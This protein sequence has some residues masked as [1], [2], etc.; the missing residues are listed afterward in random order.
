MPQMDEFPYSFPT[1]LPTI[2]TA[3]NKERSH[4]CML[5]IQSFS[6]QIWQLNLDW[7]Y[8]NFVMTN[9]PTISF[10]VGLLSV[11]LPI[12]F[13]LSLFQFYLTFLIFCCWNYT[14]LLYKSV[15]Y[16]TIQSITYWGTLEMVRSEWIFVLLCSLF[17]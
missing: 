6:C 2:A 5:E 14:N 17:C 13:S 12:C 4:K 1:L 11:L 10:T 15:V 9:I 7:M 16:I 3:E 8:G